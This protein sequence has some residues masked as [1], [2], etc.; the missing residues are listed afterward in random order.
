MKLC[1]FPAGAMTMDTSQWAIA[2]TEV[3]SSILPTVEVMA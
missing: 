1:T 3:A 2:I